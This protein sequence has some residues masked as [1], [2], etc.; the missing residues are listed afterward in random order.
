MLFKYFH[1]CCITVVKARY[2]HKAYHV[3]NQNDVYMFVLVF[4]VTLYVSLHVC[5]R[6]CVCVCVCVCVSVCV[7]V[8]LSFH[9]SVIEHILSTCTM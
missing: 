8:C 4:T 9:L 3:M 1:S 7:C 2:E 5:V 6:V